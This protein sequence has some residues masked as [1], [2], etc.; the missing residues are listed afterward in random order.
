VANIDADDQKNKATASAYEISG[1]PTIKFFPA[2]SKDKKPL[3]Y[4][5][6]RDEAGFVKFLNEKCGTQRAVGGGLNDKV[7]LRKLLRVP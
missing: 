1:Y 7:S 5:G 4:E 3:D 2:G 6:G